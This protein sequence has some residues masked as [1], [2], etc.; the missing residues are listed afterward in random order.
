M[1]MAEDT[2][3]LRCSEPAVVSAA[4]FT[5]WFVRRSE[6][7][8]PPPSL[9][10][11]ARAALEIVLGAPVVPVELTAS[12]SGEFIRDYLLARWRGVFR[13][14]LYAQSILSIPPIGAPMLNG[15][16]FHAARTNISRAHHQGI[17]CREL[18]ESERPR[19]L[20]ELNQPGPLSERS[21]ERCGAAARPI[22]SSARA[23]L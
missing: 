12:P 3:Q 16:R 8:A 6:S 4:A 22:R 5:R 13:S 23:A 2:G 21:V 19:V 11:G 20:R 14:N 7:A 10:A 18:P 15:R 9:L 17:T 1:A